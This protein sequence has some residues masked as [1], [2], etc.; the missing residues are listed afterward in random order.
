MDLLYDLEELA[1]LD[2][3][4]ITIPGDAMQQDSLLHTVFPYPTVKISPESLTATLEK[5]KSLLHRPQ[6][7]LL[8]GSF[9][10]DLEYSMIL[11]SNQISI[12]LDGI[13]IF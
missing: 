6:V 12:N 11:E 10:D 1:D 4:P 9:E 3:T 5:I 13:S 2:A 8:S 7:A